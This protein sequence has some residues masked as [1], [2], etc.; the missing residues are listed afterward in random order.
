MSDD[1][2]ESLTLE[3]AT[4]GYDKDFIGLVEMVYGKGFLSQ[5]GER[6][7][8]EMIGD[9]NLD[10]AHV[11]DIGSGLGGPSIYL[12]KRH[13]AHVTGLEPQAWMI[14]CAHKN[15]ADER[16]QL[17]GSVNFV[18][19]TT[20]SNLKQFASGSFDFVLSKEAILH[21]PL[22]VKHSFLAE[23]FRVLKPGGMFIVLDWVRTAVPYSP[24]TRQMME[25]DGVAYN[26]TTLES[27]LGSLAQVGFIEI[28]SEARTAKSVEYSQ[29]N[30]ETIHQLKDKIIG[31]YGVLTFEHSL[32]SWSW[33]RDAFKGRELETVLFKAKKPL[34]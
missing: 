21:I 1:Q 23:I 29:L 33:Q 4:Q 17:R 19:M 8:Q 10:D 34:A 28:S 13:H 7:V 20:T 16:D 18:H 32:Q 15:L 22:E 3:A 27:Y 26:L 12:T 5:G 11:L 2:M 9:F 14:E 31:M 24:N 30:V 6:S 25:L